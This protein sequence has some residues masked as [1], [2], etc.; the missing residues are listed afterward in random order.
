MKGWAEKLAQGW[1][2]SAPPVGY[3]NVTQNGKKIQIP[4]ESNWRIIKEMFSLYLKPEQTAKSITK[5]MA[6]RG[7]VTRKGRPYAHGRVVEMLKNPYY[8][9]IIRFD[10]REYPGSHQTFV[11][12]RVWME[13]QKKLHAKR[14]TYYKKH[15]PLFKNLITCETCGGC[16]TW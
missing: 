14:P 16:V 7:V 4:D 8:V 11:D 10:G 13:V 6:R 12:K 1:L 2:P 3:V 9:G 5:E 15:N